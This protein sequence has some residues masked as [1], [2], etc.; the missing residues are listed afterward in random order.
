MKTIDL[1]PIPPKD[2]HGLIFD[3]F[4]SLE[5]GESLIL[6]TD[7]EP[8]P[9]YYQF[10]AEQSDLFQW[11]T[12]EAGPEDW[13]IRITR[14]DSPVTVAM[15]ARKYPAAIPVFNRHQI[16]YCCHGDVPL[17][18]ALSEAGLTRNELMNEIRNSEAPTQTLNYDHWPMGM[19]CDF[20]VMNH[21]TFV[22]EKLPLLQRLSTK[23]A[24]VHGPENPWLDT[25]KDK[26]HVLAGELLA[27][28]EKEEEQLFP[29]IKKVEKQENPDVSGLHQL[30]ESL[31]DEH[32]VAGDLMKEIRKITGNY[33]LP[34][35]AC[36]SFG[37][38]YDELQSFEQDLYAHVHLENNI[39]FEKLE[40]KMRQV[41]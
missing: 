27:H 14:Q 41:T 38:L 29:K 28:L 6:L 32:D 30:Q 36:M 3:H 25:L 21:H 16:D 15:T 20:I 1:R 13:K 4:E 24:E 33:T 35:G 34:A 9:L 11:D 7:H 2:R 31:R 18:R 19:L 10:E 39:L 40:E 5:T 23:V 17:T 8:K 37:N 26:I 12:L 22:R